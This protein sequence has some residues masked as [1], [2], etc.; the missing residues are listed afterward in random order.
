MYTQI[1]I[2][3]TFTRE[4]VQGGAI[5][6]FQHHLTVPSLTIVIDLR[7]FNRSWHT[8]AYFKHI[9]TMVLP[10]GRACVYLVCTHL[11]GLTQH[12]IR[13]WDLTHSHNMRR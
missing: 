6:Y 12:V 10:C 2:K 8:C 5:D 1:H 3:Y 7:M 4:T 11:C 9:I 13:P